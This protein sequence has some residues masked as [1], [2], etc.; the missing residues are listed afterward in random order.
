M[1]TF[2]IIESRRIPA[3]DHNRAGKYDTMLVYIENGGGSP[4]AVVVP[5]DDPTDE[6]IKKALAEDQQRRNKLA[7]KS[8]TI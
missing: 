8:F 1:A 5:F 2:R 7:G 4:A 3:R 6:Q